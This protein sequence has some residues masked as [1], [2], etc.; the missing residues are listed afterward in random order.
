MNTSQYKMVLTNSAIIINDYELGTCPTLER[1][2]KVWDITYHRY[3]IIGMYYD[4]LN[5]RLY[6]PRGSDVDYIKRKLISTMNGDPLTSTVHRA[7]DYGYTKNIRMK[8]KPRN[9]RQ[10]EALRFML[11]KDKYSYN[12]QKTQ[13]SVNLSTGVGKTYCAT[14]AVS[15]LGIRSIIITAQSGILNQWEQRLLEY[16]DINKSE[17]VYLEGSQTLNRIIND[18]SSITNKSIYLV[19]HSTL[20]NYGST[21]G[22]ENVG[23]VFKK[24]GIGIKIFDEAHQNFYNMAMIDFFTNTWRTY[25]LTAT[26]K[27]SDR[28][29]DKIY[30]I[31]MKNIPSIE[32]FDDDIDPHTNYIAIKYNSNPKPSDVIACKNQYGLNHIAYINY[33]MTNDRFWMMFDYIFSLIYKAGGKALFY[34]GVN[35]AILKVRDRILFN[36]PELYYDIGI[37]TSISEDKAIAK[38]KKYILTTTKSAGAGEDIAHLKYSVVLAEPFRSEVLAR[39]SLG[40]TRDPNTSYIELV[41]VGFKQTLR[42]YNSKKPVF[43]K[44]AASCKNLDVDNTKLINLSEEA[45]CNIRDRFKYPIRFNEGYPTEALI[46]NDSDKKIMYPAIYFGS[47]IKNQNN[48]GVED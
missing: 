30:Q 14:G 19:T 4:E 47:E 24:L 18:Q 48:K 35:N 12:N 41:D 22:W 29:E 17:I 16:T 31:Y 11:C 38:N 8:K 15:Y 39:Q 1:N 5:K 42:Y 7:P 32:L 23:L 2:F 40:R 20:Q 34:I 3:N 27:R 28:D 36:Y 25:Y 13:F 37:Y 45:R 43:S 6:L 9:E 44:Y 21:Y 33:L 26:P 46:F 10:E